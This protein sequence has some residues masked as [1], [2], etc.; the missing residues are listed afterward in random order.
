M[1]DDDFF[2]QD[3]AKEET[4]KDTTKKNP[5]PRSRQEWTSRN[6][7]NQWPSN[8]E[9]TEDSSPLG[10][11]ELDEPVISLKTLKEIS[12]DLRHHSSE[13]CT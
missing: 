12:E 5:P 4:G 13:T 3:Q 7:I 2:N 8:K 10:L 9:L 6:G 11:L 1:F